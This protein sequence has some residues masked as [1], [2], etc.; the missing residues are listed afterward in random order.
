WYLF[1]DFEG[2]EGWIHSSLVRSIPSVI[3]KKETCNIRS[4]PGVDYD[5]VLTVGKG[6]PFKVIEEKGRWIHIL[7]ADGDSGWIHNSL[8]W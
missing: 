3:T 7:H 8:V 1:K 5:M 2:D 6:I 4:G